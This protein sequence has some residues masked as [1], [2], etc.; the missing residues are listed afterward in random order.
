MRSP[1]R[2]RFLTLGTACIGAGVLAGCGFE[3]LYGEGTAA[4]L[5]QGRIAVGPL[6]GFAGYDCR[7]RLVRLLG[8]A[9]NP[10]HLLEVNLAIDV[11]SVALTQDN[12]QT[13]Y[14]VVGDAGYTLRPLSGS[15]EILRGRTGALSG[16]SSPD[17]SAGTAFA[18]EVARQDAIR[19]VAVLLAERIALALSLRAGEWAV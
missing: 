17:N 11:E 9:E 14:R 19:R 16:Y 4:E 3:P 7:Q 12:I 5:G 6:E 1:D 15:G 13:R 8:E 18:T 2:R 10:T